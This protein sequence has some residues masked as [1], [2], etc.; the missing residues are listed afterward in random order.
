VTEDLCELSKESIEHPWFDNS[1]VPVVLAAG[2]LSKAKDYPTI[3]EAVSLILKEKKVYFAILGEGEERKNLENIIQELGIK[4]NVVLLGFQKNPYKYMAKTTIFALS[5]VLEGFP[6]VLV[7]AMACGAPVV[8]TD[9]QA[10]P[11]E[12]IDNGKNG[13][14][15]PIKNPKALAQAILKLIND[16]DLRKKFSEEGKKRAQNFSAERSAKEYEKLFLEL[17]NKIN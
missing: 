5:S 8:S 2:R 16:S 1:A 14:L 11:N 9:C 3:L 4:N 13:F 6:T 7:E 15:V 12:I 17:L 10:G